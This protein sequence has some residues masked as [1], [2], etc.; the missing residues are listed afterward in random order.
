MYVH[1]Q[2]VGTYT[3]VHACMYLSIHYKFDFEWDGRRAE[4]GEREHLAQVKWA[5][6]VAQS[7]G[8]IE[9]AGSS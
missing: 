3:P 5:G 6:E 2:R 1:V 7:L 4:M 8:Q 9:P